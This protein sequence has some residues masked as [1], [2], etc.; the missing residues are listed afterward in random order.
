MTDSS[1]TLRNCHFFIVSS[2]LADDVVE[3]VVDV[4]TGFCRGFDEGTAELTGKVFPF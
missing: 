1:V 4:Y 2:D 3:G